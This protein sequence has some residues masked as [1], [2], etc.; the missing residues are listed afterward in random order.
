MP[1]GLITAR[2][3]RA[4]AIALA[5]CL[6]P[7]AGAHGP[8]GAAEGGAMG[9]RFVRTP[10]LRLVHF[11]PLAYLA[12]YALGTFSGSLGWQRRMFGWQPSQS[13]TVL[14]KD[15]GDHGNAAA[16]AAPFNTV[17]ID[18]APPSL[19]FET[20]ASAE[21]LYSL[22]N[23]ELVHV[24]SMDV[25]DGRDRLFRR[26]FQ[27]K[28]M[29]QAQNPE[30]MLYGW[31]T[32]PRFHAPRWFHEGGAVFIETWMNGGFGRAQ[33]GYDEM[34]FRAMVRDGTPFHDPLSLVSRGVLTDF[35]VG[36]N[37]YLYGTRFV[38]WLALAHSPEK[39]L[40]W[41]R[42]DEGSAAHYAA[43][44]Q[45]V[46]GL[47]LDE[48]WQQ[49]VAFEQRFQQANLQGLRKHPVTPYR[50]LSKVAMGSVS[51]THLDA[52][53]GVLY[54][55]FRP[56]GVLEHVGALDVASGEYRRLRDIKRGMLYRVAAFA[57]DEAS[58]TAFF[59][60]D[61]HAWRDLVALDV[62]SG[63][64][65]VLIESARI[66]ELA[67]NRAD[68]ALWGVRHH[69]GVA[70]LVRLAPPYTDWTEVHRFAYG[71]VPSDLDISADGRLLSATVNEVNGDMFLRVWPIER[72]L[73]G[74]LKPQRE[75][76]FGLAVPESFVFTR[77]GRG[78]IGSSYYT[79]VS[80]IFRVDLG[81]GEMQALSNAETG[82]FRPQ[83]LPDGR[84]VVLAYTG[85]GFV[86]AI[87]DGQPLKDV[88]AI[89]FLGREV[90]DKHPVLTTWQVP[91]PDTAAAEKQVLERGPYF[92]LRELRLAN[93]YP[94]LQGYKSQAGLGWRFN[95][96]DPTRFAQW[97]AIVAYTPGTREL[98]GNQDWHLD[99]FGS[100]L[101]WRAGVA[102]NRSDFY[103]LFGPTKR[104]RK[105]YALRLGYDH[106]LLYDD[107]RKLELS[108]DLAH[109]GKIDTLPDAQNVGSGFTQL[110][111]LESRLAYSNLRRSLGA[112][113]DESGVTASLRAGASRAG[114][115]SGGAQNGTQLRGAFDIGLA[116]PVP[117]SSLWSRS[118]WGVAGG[119]RSN[120]MA[121]FYFGGF[122][123]NV[124]DN[125]AVK[126]YREA[127][128]MPGFELN[129]IAARRYLKQT[130][131][132][133]LPPLLFGRFGTPGLHATWLRPAVF[134]SSLWA[135][136][137]PANPVRQRWSSLGGQLDLRISTLHWYEMMLS[138]GYARGQSPSGAR[139]DEWMLSLKIL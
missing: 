67:F 29:P 35:Q 53:R 34:V 20:N 33:G 128:S 19:A 30:S 3:V 37:A 41:I 133:T 38:T 123:N 56:A 86:P 32:Q 111:T 4:I 75:F 72:L 127:D 93:A 107:P 45:L 15:F 18:V 25:A 120:P 27:G 89:R 90:V 101:G 136:G 99:V 105:G 73:A 39:V 125:G 98:P 71:V 119:E 85:A 122:G 82:F 57:F 7:A 115:S 83:E 11:E 138:L 43:Q 87:I 1:P 48:A 55:A 70:S 134:A 79:G 126:R 54:G 78:L 21:R 13:T 80:N 132:W 95:F 61:N 28:V 76:S 8:D 114:G 106:F 49:W 88:S 10:D 103:D 26:L 135:Q 42:R 31:L 16:W 14:L 104:A 129:Q 109:R 121:S 118:A 96:E 139:S 102:W 113:D 62:A 44:F 52:T 60:N 117:H 110:T 51:R 94:V 23:H 92:P 131:E 58:G 17:F 97:S 65:R 40:K 81:G 137:A 108:T 68:R 9:L 100:Y 5:L 46:F 50:P 116:L 84:L 112:V 66:G 130:V 64:Q 91:A 24:A 36:A 77:D 74:D 59:T 12:P 47:P 6:P 63:E 22:M 69:E 2:L 124:V